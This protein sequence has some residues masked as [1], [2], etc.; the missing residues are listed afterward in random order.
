MTP[1]KRLAF[2]IAHPYD[3]REATDAAHR[4][5]QGVLSELTGRSGVGDELEQLDEDLR[6][7]ITDAVADIIR[8]AGLK[9]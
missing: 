3:E 7:E 4:A 8:A 2:G 6:I 5:A 9:G 1:E